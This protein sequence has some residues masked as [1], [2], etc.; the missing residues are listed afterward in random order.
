MSKSKLRCTFPWMLTAA[1]LATAF[2]P[3]AH[4]Q[5]SL[6]ARPLVRGRINTAERTIL[7]G[8][9]RSAANAANDRGQVAG[10]LPLDHMLLV[11][12]LSP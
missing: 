8:N 5:G 6:S 7:P 9:V 3:F 1:S 12:N 2:T 11:L 10:S 4:G